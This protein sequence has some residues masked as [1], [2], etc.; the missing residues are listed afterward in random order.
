MNEYVKK[1]KFVEKEL[2]AL[3][4]QIY[5]DIVNVTYTKH[6]SSEEF[7]NVYF[8]NGCK[9]FCVTADSLYAIVKDVINNI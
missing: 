4:K 9:S 6:Q 8:E 1:Q 3:L 7:V 5:L 2:A